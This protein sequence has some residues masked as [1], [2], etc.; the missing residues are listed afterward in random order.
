MMD[1]TQKRLYTQ[2]E[3][4]CVIRENSAQVLCFVRLHHSSSIGKVP[5]KQGRV[6]I[7]AGTVEPFK[8]K[9]LK[10]EFFT[11]LEL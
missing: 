5:K 4:L 1:F 3:Y 11:L 2:K 10:F 9:D 8:T 7:L 6:F